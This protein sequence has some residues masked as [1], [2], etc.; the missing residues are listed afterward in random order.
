MQ[1]ITMFEILE[2]EKKELSEFLKEHGFSSK[3]IEK[4]EIHFHPNG[5][6]SFVKPVLRF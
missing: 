6:I 3:Y 2:G 1:K 4:I 5:D